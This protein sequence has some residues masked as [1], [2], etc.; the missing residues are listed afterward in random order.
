MT[1]P[2]H[3]SLSIFPYLFHLPYMHLLLE[4]QSMPHAFPPICSAVSVVLTSNCPLLSL[5]ATPSSYIAQSTAQ[6]QSLYHCI[7]Q[8]TVVY[9]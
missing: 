5:G 9:S 7:T 6:V 4:F 1:R 3:F 8:F 2:V